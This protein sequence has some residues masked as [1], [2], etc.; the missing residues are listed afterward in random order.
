MPELESGPYVWD[1]WIGR[2]DALTTYFKPK[3]VAQILSFLGTVD[4]KKLHMRAVG[5]GHST[6]D[7]ARPWRL[8]NDDKRAG[9]V[10][11]M[12]AVALDHSASA[13]A[14]WRDDFPSV[15]AT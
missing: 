2:Q 11:H 5:S 13:A 10:L 4:P 8:P 9:I 14:W 1:D 6:S 7:V 3:S 12:E 15:L